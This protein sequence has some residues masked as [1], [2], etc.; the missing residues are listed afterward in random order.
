[1]SEYVDVEPD[2]EPIGLAVV[3]PGRRYRPDQPLLHFTVGV[4]RDRGW[5]VRT[6][7]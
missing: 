3:L 4:L 7:W 2:G 6:L 1:M 5:R